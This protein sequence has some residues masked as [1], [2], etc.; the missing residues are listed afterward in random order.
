MN[1]FIGTFSFVL[2]FA[3]AAF[4]QSG[5]VKGKVIIDSNDKSLPGVEITASQEGKDLKSTTLTF[6]KDGYSKSSIKFEVKKGKITDLSNRRLGMMADRANFVTIQGT[7]FDQ[8]GFSLSGA[9]VEI[10]R[11]TG[12]NVWEKLKAIYSSEDGEFLFRFTPLGKETNYRITVTYKNVE[13]QVKEKTV[14][15]AGIYRLAFNLP[16]KRQ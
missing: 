8:D 5:G 4:A 3:L 14:D 10:A 16:V 15:F 1:R 6:D 11:L 2:L 9:K 13:P 12:G 7:V